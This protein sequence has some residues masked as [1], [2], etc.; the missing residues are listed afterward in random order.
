MTG[1]LAALLALL[2][3]G[4]SSAVAGGP[5]SV[6]VGSPESEKATALYFSDQRYEQLQRLL[7]PVDKGV[8]KPPM[9]AGMASARQ[10]NVTWLVHDMSPW[11]IDRVF[12]LK[13]KPY[14]V[15]I[16][17]AAHPAESPNGYWHR[18]EHPDQLRTLLKELGLMGK[19]REGGFSGAFPGP[20]QSETPGTTTEEPAASAP[21]LST[22]T[23]VTRDT[24][25]GTTDTSGTDGSGWWW[26]IP[27]AA[28]GAALALLLRPFAV[29]MASAG[30]RQE[31]RQQKLIDL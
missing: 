5:T 14:A 30:L 15:W 7:G 18:A 16:H 6:L 8:R 3:W 4:A 24:A 21:T 2:L 31:E 12:P 9:E 22:G 13:S 23:R 28:V 1:A 17:T 11:R 29:H 20:W 10:I 26:A 19:A 25:A 27:G